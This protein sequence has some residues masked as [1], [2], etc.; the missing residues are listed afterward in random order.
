MVHVCE[1]IFDRLPCDLKT[2]LMLIKVGVIDNWNYNNS[3][4]FDSFVNVCKKTVS[5]I[6][7]E[8]NISFN[9]KNIRG[10]KNIKR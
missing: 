10:N 1:D 3:Q 4:D 5:I 6:L 7:A 9:Q 2:L 8:K